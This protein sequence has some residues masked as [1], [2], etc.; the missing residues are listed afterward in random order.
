MKPKFTIKLLHNL[1]VHPAGS[2]FLILALNLFKDVEDFIFSGTN[3]QISGPLND[4]VY[5][6]FKTVWTFLE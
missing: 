6:P 1:H 5:V 4:I 3:A 2:Q